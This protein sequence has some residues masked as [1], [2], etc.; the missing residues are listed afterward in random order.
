[1]NEHDI[2]LEAQQLARQPGGLVLAATG[3][4]GSPI[5]A[6]VSPSQGGQWRVSWF[7]KF[8]FAGNTT[9]DTKEACI[10]LC[11]EEGY[12]DTNRNL[13]TEL[14]RLESFHEGCERTTAVARMHGGCMT[15]A[16]AR[17]LLV[18]ATLTA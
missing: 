9:P 5:G 17:A 3:W 1:M 10:L 6:M 11:L 2:H 18:R 14:S 8:G 7:D 4:N 16:Q 15:N 13:L 12:T